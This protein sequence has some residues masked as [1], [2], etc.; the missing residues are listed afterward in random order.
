MKS[1]IRKRVL[2]AVISAAML[3]AAVPCGGIWAANVEET[4]GVQ[5]Q[6]IVI[7]NDGK[8]WTT[9]SW[10]GQ[11]LTPN[12]SWTTLMLGDYYENGYL[13]F[14]VKNNASSTVEFN[15]GLTSK[16]HGEQVRIYWT[17]M[18]EYED[19]S[20][21]SEWK[22]YSLP[23]KDVVDAYPDSGFD[24]DNFW[25]V[26]VNGV[27]SGN[28]LSFQ[29]MTITSTDDERQYQ[30][31]KV[32]QVGYYCNAAKTAR[33]S[34]FEKFGSL[35]GQTFEIVNADTGEITY[36]D[37]LPDAVYEEKFSGEM[38]H[39]INFDEVTEPGSYYIRIPDAGLDPSACSSRD[40]A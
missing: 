3:S 31:V 38:V 33:V 26:Y 12:T 6:S 16:K 11:N 28:T 30:I 39:V 14:E 35:N 23:I 32:N 17:D 21:G 36:T 18:E 5:L 10:G 7:D 15:I 4:P 37:S 34:Y 9:E 29:N 27:P 2:A 1:T 22:S 19:I 24:L 8:N 40:K 25:L 13:N 20:A